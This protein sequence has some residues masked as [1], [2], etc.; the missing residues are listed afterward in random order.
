MPAQSRVSGGRIEQRI[1]VL[2]Y[3]RTIALF[4]VQLTL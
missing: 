4:A 2:F 3:E 1:L